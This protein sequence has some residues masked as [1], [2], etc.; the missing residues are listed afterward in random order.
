M[1]RVI[2]GMADFKTLLRRLGGVM[3]GFNDQT[4][5]AYS[6]GSYPCTIVSPGLFIMVAGL[7]SLYWRVY[8]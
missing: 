2:D 6:F 1:L 7:S 3:A 4:S 5:E 8:S